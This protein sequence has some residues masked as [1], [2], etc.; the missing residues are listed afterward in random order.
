MI[1]AK[2]NVIKQLM[3]ER[4]W[5]YEH[6]AVESGLSHG[7]VTMLLRGKK[8]VGS[9]TIKHI[10]AVFDMPFDELFEVV[11]PEMASV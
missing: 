11:V 1:R 10:L 5:K 4:N 6:L 8:S 7:A 2:V 9:K 3:S